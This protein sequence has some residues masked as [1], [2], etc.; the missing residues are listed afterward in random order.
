MSNKC[1]RDV[2]VQ[3]NIECVQIKKPFAAAYEWD[4]TKSTA[5]LQFSFR[6][7]EVTW[8]RGEISSGFCKSVHVD[9]RLVEI[10]NDLEQ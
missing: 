1:L 6:S 5:V 9:V 3:V 4:N 10:Q 7:D 2:A 8:V